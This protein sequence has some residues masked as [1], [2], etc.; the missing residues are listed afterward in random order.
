MSVADRLDTLMS[1]TLQFVVIIGEDA[2]WAAGDKLKCV[3]HKV[4]RTL[5]VSDTEKDD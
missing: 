5:K 2:S 3:G 4:C 1:D